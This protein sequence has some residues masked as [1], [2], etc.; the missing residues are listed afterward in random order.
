M[1]V[2]SKLPG[3]ELDFSLQ[4]LLFLI[5]LE[6]PGQGAVARVV[7]DAGAGFQARI[8]AKIGSAHSR[9][10]GDLDFSYAR[11]WAGNN[12]ERDID[13]LFLRVRS[14]CLCDCRSR[15]SVF[16][17]CAAH[18]FERLVQFG[19][20]E[21]SA[22]RQLTCPHELGVHGGAFGAVH[23]DR[24]N[25]SPGS[26]TEDNV[27]TGGFARCFGL[28]VVEKSRRIELTKAFPQ[29]FRA[30]RFA[31]L[32]LELI[33]K[34]VQPIGC[35]P[36]EQDAAYGQ[37]FEPGE[38]TGAA[39]DAISGGQSVRI[40]GVCGAAR[41]TWLLAPAVN[42]RDKKAHEQAATPAPIVASH[43]RFYLQDRISPL[44]GKRNC[45]VRYHR[46]K[47]QGHSVRARA[48]LPKFPI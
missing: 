32:L 15:K 40:G 10:A 36:L 17:F 45:A 9:I 30:E 43:R 46:I 42:C 31:L 4:A 38:G 35:H 34:R 6:H 19:L 33:R 29:V 12:L 25:K 8:A 5:S 47:Q 24:A 7:I 39:L 14:Q 23:S 21:P 18:R 48:I 41:V 3:F 11:L 1:G 22:G 13:K 37:A 44:P 2:W 27:H 20:G 28:N 16:G 26:T